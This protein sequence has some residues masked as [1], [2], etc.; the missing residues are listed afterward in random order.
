M[1]SSDP[2]AH[3][4]EGDSR[5]CRGVDNF[6]LDIV[7]GVASQQYQANKKGI[8]SLTCGVVRFFLSPYRPIADKLE[9]G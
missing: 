6:C 2:S 9:G 7:M 1:R 8:L 4:D 3:L 5:C